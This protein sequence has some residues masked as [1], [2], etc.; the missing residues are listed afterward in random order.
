MVVD[1]AP[2]DRKVAV[3]APPTKSNKSISV[4]V[5]APTILLPNRL[6]LSFVA[7]SSIYLVDELATRRSVHPLDTVS[8]NF[9]LQYIG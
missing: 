4:I 1:I 3:V 5:E 6:K 7:N 8:M 9:A 2:L